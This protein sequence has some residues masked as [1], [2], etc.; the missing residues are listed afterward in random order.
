MKKIVSVMLA[1]VL[2]CGALNA[3]SIKVTNTFG[4]DSDNISGSDLFVFE[5]Q[6]DEEGSY[7]NEFGNKT[8]VSDR[9]QLDASVSKF[10]SRIRIEFGATKLNGKDSLFVFAVTD[11]L[12]R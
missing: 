10:D 11:V 1:G 6:K 7:E 3:Q 12:N 5:N 2:L 8:R 4:G 9:L